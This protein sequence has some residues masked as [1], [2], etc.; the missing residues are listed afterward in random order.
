MRSSRTLRADLLPTLRAD[1]WRSRHPKLTRPYFHEF[2]PLLRQKA[3][4]VEAFHRAFGT[5]NFFADPAIE[6]PELR[7][8]IAMLLE[9][10]AN[11]RCQPVLRG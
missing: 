10:A 9:H 5:E 11:Q 4:G 3:P 8:Y 6:L 2:A 1:G 7:A